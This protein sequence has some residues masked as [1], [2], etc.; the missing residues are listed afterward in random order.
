MKKILIVNNNMKVG[1]VQK[2]LYNLLWS[3]DHRKYQVTLLLFSKRGAYIDDLP[4]EVRVAECRG[5]FRYLGMS[6]GECRGLKDRL[7]RGLLAA[8]SRIIGRKSTLALTA[9]FQ[10]KEREEYDCA[11]SFLHNGRA[12]SFYGGT[13]DYLLYCVKARKKVAFLHCD[14]RNCGADHK[15]NNEML[16]RFDLIAACSEGCKRAFEK[17]VPQL[18]ERC[19]TVSNCHRFDLI[20]ELAEQDPIQY[21]KE[22]LNALIVARLSREKGIERAI[23]AVGIA[24]GRGLPVRLHVVGGGALSRELQGQA[25]EAGLEGQVLFYGEQSNPYRY[26]KNADLLVLSSY[27]EAAPMV[28]DEARCLGLPVLTTQ[29][30][31]AQDMVAE[32]GCGFVCENSKEGIAEALCRIAADRTALNTLRCT[33]ENSPADNRRGLEQFDALTEESGSPKSAGSVLSKDDKSRMGKSPSCGI[34]ENDL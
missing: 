11:I 13:Q 24:K 8:S 23:E 10:K 12:R 2:S 22:P 15:E 30:T 32:R 21:D 25:R 4:P 29:T 16:A 20:R 28:I 18:A 19:V 26:M 7:V 34:N 17:T 6:Q 1:G 9:V 33:L 14:Y 5:P 27:H 3:I 31:S